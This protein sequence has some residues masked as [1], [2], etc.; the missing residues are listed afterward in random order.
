MLYNKHGHQVVLFCIPI[1]ARTKVGKYKSARIYGR[2]CRGG[3][4]FWSRY[5]LWMIY[6]I[7][8]N[9]CAICMING[10]KEENI[11]NTFGC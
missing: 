3:S 1:N 6:R 7:F 9:K 8:A 11:L 2:E 5:V 4:E 10:V